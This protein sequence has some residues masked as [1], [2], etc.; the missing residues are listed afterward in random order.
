MVTAQR[1]A[2]NLQD[3]PS[4]ITALSETVI[5]RADIHDLTDIATRIPGLTFSPFSPGQNIVA[6]RGASSND[7]GA[8]TDNSVAVFVDDVYL[9]RVSNINPEMFDIERIEVLRGPQGT[10]YGKNTIGGAINVVS[11]KPGIEALQGKLRLNVGNFQRR[12]VAGLL[13]GPLSDHWAA[14]AS[15]S[16]RKRDGW[17]DNVYLNKKQKDDDVVA[18]RGQLLYSGE[19]LESAVQRRFQSIG[20][21]RHGA[22]PDR[23]RGAGR[24]GVLGGQGTGQPCGPLQGPGPGLFRGSD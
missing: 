14:K 22:H 21:G 10:L 7:D 18:L 23:Y 13:S 1:R 4:A 24:P 20:C 9:G 2:E 5:E 19:R 15:L 12:E 6:L 11:R 16:Y 8:G 17:V 3:V